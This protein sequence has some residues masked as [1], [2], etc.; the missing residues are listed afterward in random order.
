M[1][2]FFLRPVYKSGR[3]GNRTRA[4]GL[5]PAYNSYA[6]PTSPLREHLRVHKAVILFRYKLLILCK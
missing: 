5:I 2:R 3:T 4:D 6:N 1:M